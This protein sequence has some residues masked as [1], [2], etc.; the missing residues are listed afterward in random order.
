[1]TKTELL[2]RLASTPEDRLL[3]A[4]VLDKMELCRRRNVPAHTPFLSLGE[5]KLAQEA[6]AACGSPAH[7]FWG[8]YEEAERTVCA[9]LPDWMEP[10]DWTAGPDCPVAAVELSFPAD[11]GLTHRDFLGSILGLGLDREKLGDLLVGEG[12]CQAVLLTD[13]Q[14]TLLTQLDQVG[15]QRVRVAPLDPAKLVVPAKTVKRIRDT[16]ATLR[17]D[18]VAATGFSTSRSK[19]AALISSKKVQLNGREVDK[20]DRT[21]EAGDVLV[22]RG[23]G[24]CVLAAV[25]GESRKG[26]IMIEIERY[27]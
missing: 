20:P 8:G 16:V 4:R 14:N 13:I 15:R 12:T 22:C 7:R 19:M 10:E 26:R 25:T 9:F 11:S 23:L 27:V 2:D 3:L 18:A 24:K 17:L 1:M 6:I 5:R 21:V